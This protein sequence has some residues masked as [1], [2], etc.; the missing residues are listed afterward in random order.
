MAA[1]DAISTDQTTIHG[2]ALFS[3][4]ILSKSIRYVK[5]CRQG[6]LLLFFMPY[7]MS[8]QMLDSSKLDVHIRQS[9]PGKRHYNRTRIHPARLPQISRHDWDIE[10]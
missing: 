3:T 7:S 1:R 5:N 6:A 2:R 4:P 10:M 8:I 9:Q